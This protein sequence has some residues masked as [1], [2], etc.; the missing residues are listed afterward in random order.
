VSGTLAVLRRELIGMVDSP[1][2]WV[3]TGAAVLALHGAFFF[4]G[5]PVGDVH[6]PSFWDGAV[7]SLDALF[8]WIPL[9]L[10]ILAPALSMATWA[11]ERR[12]GTDELLLTQPLGTGAAV[13]GKFLGVWLFLCA[14]LVVVVVPAAVVVDFVGP[15]DRGTVLGGLV[16]AFMLAGSCAAIGGLA[17]ALS[18]EQLVAFLLSAGVLLGLW[19][20]GLF[21]RVL[22]GAAAELAWY[23]SPA[24]HFVD[25]GARGVFD[26]RDVVHHG[27]LAFAGLLGNV[28]AVEARRWRG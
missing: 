18:S 1:V 15:L 14:L 7:A 13:L 5:Y 16:G 19:A 12:A 23:A 17:S 26:L 6:L 11:E 22:P 27:L 24:L 28:V 21:V 9:A 20:A 2:A 8:A 10:A 25:S 4:L 3:A